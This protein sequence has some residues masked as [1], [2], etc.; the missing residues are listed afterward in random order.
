MKIFSA[1]LRELAFKKY[2]LEEE[3][4]ITKE[5]AVKSSDGPLLPEYC[6]NLQVTLYHLSHSHEKP[7]E[8]E[9]S[10]IVPGALWLPLY[11]LYIGNDYKRA[12]LFMGARVAQKSGEDWTD[13]ELH[14]SA[15]LLKE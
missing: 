13:A 1:E 3:I 7:K 2:K 15:Q 14:F 6:K 5:T 11:K 12:G 8:I 10:Y 4:E 9:I